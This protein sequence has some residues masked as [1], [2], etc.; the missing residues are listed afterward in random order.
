MP[1]PIASLVTV[2]AAPRLAAIALA[3]FSARAESGPGGASPRIR[4]SRKFPSLGLET[5]EVWSEAAG[6]FGWRISF[7]GGAPRSG[8][9]LRLE[10]PIL[11]PAR[12]VFAPTERG[13][14]DLRA[15]PSFEPVPYAHVGW[16]DGR[17]Y[18]LPLVSAFD[19][20]AGR[21][22]TIALPPEPPIPHLQVSWRDARVL[23]IRFGHRALGGGAPAEI[24]ILFYASDDDRRAVIGAYAAVF[25]RYFLPGLPRGPHEGA[26]WYHHIHDRPSFDEL[27][28]EDVRYLWAS[29]WF[30]H[31]G[32]YLPDAAEWHPYTYA[33]SWKLGETM[34]DA[35]IRAFVKEL[36][37]RGIGTFAYLNLTEYGGAGGPEGDAREAERRIREGL[38][39]ALVR[40][41]DGRPI[42]TW[43]GAF[44][45]T[46]RP[47]GPL[48]PVLR[49]E[50]E[51]H[52]ER[53]PEIAG[54][55]IDRLDW[56]SA[57]DWGRA[58]GIAMVGTRDV[59][60]LAGPVAAALA[61]VC[62]LAHAAGKRVFANQFWRVE[63]LRDVDGYC[64]E[65]DCLRGIGYLAPFRPAAA[66]HQE[67]PYS[68]DLLAFEA[69]LKTRL[70]FAV[71]PH[72]IA[73]EF[74]LAQQ[75]PDPE[76]ADLLEVY[77]PLF[78]PLRG[79]V[80][81][82]APRCV[83]AGG[84][85]QANLFAEPASGV[86][87]AAVVSRVHFLSRGGA[88]SAPAR[89]RIHIPDAAGLAWVHV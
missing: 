77:A 8:H 1:R 49:K 20:A 43:E 26:F 80:Q 34:T 15:Y 72:M 7:E 71:F 37:D 50:V 53:L 82:L 55:V 4:V 51:R 39:D 79:K 73:R 10:I 46:P 84:P 30:A 47:G 38:E 40:G 45:V 85:N 62:R 70:L 23:E 57:Y 41:E 36:S 28:R 88:R 14:M 87:A 75:A 33:R 13:A 18:V 11:D 68:G 83:E 76:A 3:L 35:K 65:Y 89:L 54:F 44:A 86:Y 61:E 42:P 60:C 67:K 52:I 66:W 58:D 12:S 64:H 59:E 63:V 69:Q 29:F 21:A 5:R 17:Y 48:L 2:A 16:G 22:L 27:A 6:I 31:L 56:A 81:V 24:Q 32:E 78:A 19:P 25:P 74:P 9:E